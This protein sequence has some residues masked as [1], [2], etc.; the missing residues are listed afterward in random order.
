VSSTVP[1]PAAKCPAAR[2]DALDEVFAQLPAD[3]AEPIFRLLAQI[4][5]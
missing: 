1:R 3:F 2:G 4:G 5:G